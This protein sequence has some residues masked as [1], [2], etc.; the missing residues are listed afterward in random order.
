MYGGKDMSIYE[1]IQYKLIKK[2]GQIE[3][4]QYDDV[5]LVSTKT[6]LNHSR[7]SGFSNVFRYIS[8]ANQEKEKISM[9]TPVVTYEDDDQLITG[10]YVPSK[11]NRINVP[12]PID[13]DVFINEIKQSLY[14]VIRFRGR[15]TESNFQKNDQK[16]RQYIEENGFSIQSQRYLFR[17]QPPFVPAIFRRNELAYKVI[18]VDV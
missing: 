6:Q 8:G 12:M 18:K 3:L 17:Y 11:Y 7:D 10:F 2:D 15:W 9:T 13:Q 14:A 4:R 5:L 1:T 16:L